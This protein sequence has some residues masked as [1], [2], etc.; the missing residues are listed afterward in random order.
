MQPTK[1]ESF[2]PRGVAF[3][4]NFNH[5]S[6]K[7]L[8]Y[9]YLAIINWIHSAEFFRIKILIA[10]LKIKNLINYSTPHSRTWKG[11]KIFNYEVLDSPCIKPFRKLFY[12]N[13]LDALAF[14]IAIRALKN[15]KWR[16]GPYYIWVVFV[17][18]YTTLSIS[19]CNLVKSVK[20]KNKFVIHYFSSHM[21]RL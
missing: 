21:T 13:K 11:T 4:S 12:L 7:L 14:L 19:Y 18:R 9:E 3:R 5:K 17:S 2:N 15:T 10:K 6:T 20:A 8:F 16:L 1:F